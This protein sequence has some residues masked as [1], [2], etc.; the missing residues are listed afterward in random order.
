MPSAYSLCS[1][2]LQRTRYARL[3]FSELA[4]LDSPSANSL[5]SAHFARFYN[6]LNKSELSEPSAVSFGKA[7]TL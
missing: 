5:R 7:K 6:G 4:M 2:R 3:A 1:T